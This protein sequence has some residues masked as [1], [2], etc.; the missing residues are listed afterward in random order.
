MLSGL[1]N[2]QGDWRIKK[3]GAYIVWQFLM[4]LVKTTNYEL[5]LHHSTE[6]MEE[7]QDVV[8]LARKIMH[9]W[10]KDKKL[11][12]VYI[13]RESKYQALLD[14]LQTEGMT[15]KRWQDIAELLALAEF[16]DIPI[17][18]SRDIIKAQQE[19]EEKEVDNGDR[20]DIDDEEE[21]EQELF[22]LNNKIR[23]YQ[24]NA[25]RSNNLISATDELIMI[26]MLLELLLFDV[27]IRQSL[28][29]AGKNSTTKELRDEE[30]EFKKYYKEWK[31]ENAKH[32]INR[33]S[34]S[35]RIYQL[36]A[37]KG[38]QA[39]LQQ[40]RTDLDALETLIRDEQH[41]LAKKK[42]ELTIHT[43]KQEKRVK[44]IGCDMLQ[45]EYW[46]FNNILD[47]LNNATDYRNSEPYWAYG[48]VIIGPGFQS[49]GNN[50]RQWWYIKG[51]EDLKKL[52]DFI[53]NESKKEQEKENIE[54]LKKIANGINYRIEYLVS[55]ETC[56]YGEGFF[57]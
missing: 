11:D 46:I 53:V 48:V 1:Q 45:N 22:E 16:K 9:S 47:H 50:R 15:P 34:L 49:G 39:E 31:E 32:V 14:V 21:E 5:P 30:L 3:F 19:E 4:I 56:V 27:Q 35:S 33:T 18:T 40:A 55:L 54:E 25:S 43:L 2:V 7:D 13:D 24:K 41:N 36:E 57:K 51:K 6:E 8:G 20:M 38:K 29:A 26:N 12:N 37:T 10:I 28:V 52:K 23:K 17:P 44:S 42:L